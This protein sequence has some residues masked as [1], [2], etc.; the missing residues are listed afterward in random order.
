MRREVNQDLN[1]RLQDQVFGRDL[2]TNREMTNGR[3][4]CACS[5][6]ETQ[7]RGALVRG[8]LGLGLHPGGV[9]AAEEVKEHGRGLLE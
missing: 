4:R 6:R 3:A 1:V 8:K 2:K 5:G 9:G 7:L